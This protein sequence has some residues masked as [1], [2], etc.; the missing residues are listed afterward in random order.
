[1]ETRG[2]IH[3][4]EALYEHYINT[5]DATTALSLRVL[6]NA[7]SIVSCHTC[8]VERGKDDNQ[9]NKNNNIDNNNKE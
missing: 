5:F 2:L 8:N 9:I 7:A 3:D 1:L 6:I 4:K